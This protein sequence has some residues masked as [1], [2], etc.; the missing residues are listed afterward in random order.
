MTLAPFS[1]LKDYSMYNFTP[2]SHTHSPKAMVLNQGKFYSQSTFGNIF[3]Y[4]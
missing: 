3:R 1:L 2:Y 4:F